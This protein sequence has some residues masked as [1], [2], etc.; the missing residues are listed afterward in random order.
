M[1]MRNEV[2]GETPRG[3]SHGSPH[4]T[5]SHPQSGPSCYGLWSTTDRYYYYY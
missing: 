1:K 2:D 4:R 3:I 5:W